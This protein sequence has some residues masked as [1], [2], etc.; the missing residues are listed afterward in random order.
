MKMLANAQ[1]VS[2]TDTHTLDCMITRAGNSTR[3]RTVH[4]V[5]QRR[6]RV[7]CSHGCA[8]APLT[9]CV[10]DS[11]LPVSLPTDIRQAC[12]HRVFLRRVS[13]RTDIIHHRGFRPCSPSC[14]HQRHHLTYGT[15]SIAP[16]HAHPQSRYEGKACQATAL[17]GCVP[18]AARSF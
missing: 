18:E 2:S 7:S 13:L 16:I 4:L 14:Q 9:Y 17:I 6:V 8:W 15:R 3:A 1:E 11:L 12:G 5:N 10:P